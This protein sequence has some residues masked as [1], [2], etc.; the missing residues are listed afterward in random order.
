MD[1]IR[2][3]ELLAQYF[4]HTINPADCE[5]LLAYLSA[6]RDIAESSGVFDE[7]LLNRND[8]PSFK[9]ENADKVFDRIK[10][11]G[12]FTRKSVIPGKTPQ[13][14]YQ[15]IW[16]R[17]A[18]ILL[19]VL[20]IG[21]LFYLNNQTLRQNS[22]TSLADSNASK[23][24]SSVSIL[25][26]SDGKVVEL[27]SVKNGLILIANGAKISKSKDG[28]LIY[29]ISSGS[30]NNQPEFHTLF[31]AKGKEY[32]VNLPDGT[33][34]WLNSS[35]ELIFPTRFSGSDRTVQLNGEA[36][37]EVA[38]NKDKPFKV[39]AHG[40]TVRVLG[41]H[42]NIMAYD[43]EEAVTTTLL[44]GAVKVGMANR[45]LTIAPGQQAIVKR[46][47]NSIVVSEV[48][49]ADAMA[50]KNGYFK[51]QDEDIKSIMKKV[52]RWYDV[53]VEYQGDVD[54]Q[55]FGG[56]FY[57]AKSLAELLNYLEKLGTVKFKIAGRR[58]I[59]MA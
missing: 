4:N 42:F 11:S 38:K 22:S 37:F 56:T 51:F 5:E 12:E 14:L 1:K 28:Q 10:T 54:D 6:N 25:K 8:G 26:L 52:C 17:V 44:E 29:D 23:S 43:D 36:Y 32:Q 21:M 18:A 46:A 3:K 59:V 55:R 9:A 35:S 30:G 47:G 48:N 34:V 20:S 40:T 19:V 16:F 24:L 53:E 45:E 58:I 27:D 13:R 15:N 50:W 57:R 33:R 2:L 31:T 49:I 41:T 39:S 7:L